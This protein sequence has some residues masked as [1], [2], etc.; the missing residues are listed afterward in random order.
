MTNADNTKENAVSGAEAQS[1][2]RKFQH[3]LPFRLL[4]Q[5]FLIATNYLPVWLLRL[6][7]RLFVVLFIIFNFDNYRAIMR[8]LSK[9]RHGIRS[10]SYAYMAYEVFKNYSYYLIDLFHLSHGPERLE[11]YTFTIRGIENVEEALG[12]GK[13]I[14]FLATH[15]GNWELGSLKLSC[16]DR[17]IHV[18][19]A[20]DSSSLLGSQLRYLRDADGVQEVPLKA[21]NFSSL[22]LLRILQEG[23]VV[24]LQ[25]DRLT[26]DRGVAV[27]FFGHDALFPKGPVKLAL[28]SDSIVLPIFIPI[29][30][31]KTYTIIIEEP[32]LMDRGDG[33]PD[34][35]KT[36]LH[37]IIRILEKYIR[38]YP[39]QWFTFM[40]FW[41][42][43]KKEFQR[44]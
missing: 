10:S 14:V 22:K 34:E 30:G 3:T 13:G 24:G 11:K 40:P 44:K 28:V 41:E 29:T 23:G 42:V 21:G 4:V 2:F 15:L 17:K 1:V 39:T 9:I 19:Y 6:I 26:F 12:T 7:G 8:N 43:D 35:L 33:L 27:P 36:N 20:P 16:K 31:Y 5:G 37:K 32:I 38:L 25:G 18:V